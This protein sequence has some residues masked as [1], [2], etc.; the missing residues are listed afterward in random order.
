V[1]ESIGGQA[2]R[3]LAGSLASRTTCQR[4]GRLKCC[5]AQ[6]VLRERLHGTHVHA[7]YV[8]LTRGIA[9]ERHTSRHTI[10]QVQQMFRCQ[11]QLLLLLLH[12][13]KSWTDKVGCY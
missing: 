1:R 9:S 6:G 13:L 12:M 5:W 11:L 8:C 4:C 3:R 7:S 2:C 10:P